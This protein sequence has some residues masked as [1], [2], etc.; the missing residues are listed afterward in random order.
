MQARQEELDTLRRVIA[1]ENERWAQA[2]AR[3]LALGDVVLAVPRDVLGRI[4]AT[5]AP[6]IDRMGHPIIRV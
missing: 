4:D 6:P 3:I 2:R 5:C 1:A